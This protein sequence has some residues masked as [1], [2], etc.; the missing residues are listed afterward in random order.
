MMV[1]AQGAV[2]NQ[3]TLTRMV[4]GSRKTGKSMLDRTTGQE[5]S[6]ANTL[7]M[8]GWV[9]LGEIISLVGLARPTKYM[10]L[11]LAFAIT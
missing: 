9:M 5:V 8:R 11:A 2:A 4:G 3:H 1:A 6:G 7:M 10:E